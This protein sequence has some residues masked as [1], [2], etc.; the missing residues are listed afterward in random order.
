MSLSP[1]GFFAVRTPLLPIEAWL[2]WCERADDPDGQ[3]AVLRALVADPAVREALF[4]G[5]PDLEGAVGAWERE[6]DGERGRRVERAVLRY[7]SRMAT[8]P[9]P[10]GLFAGT[11]VGTIGDRTQLTLVARS[12]YR[13]RTR[14][15][16]GYLDGLA[17]ALAG[18][19]A[20]RGAM[21]YRPNSSLYATAGRL[22]YVESR[23][24]DSGATSG[25]PA[26]SSRR[27]E[28][29]RA[30]T[31]SDVA[32]TP[33][34]RATLARAEGA[35]GATAT[36]LADALASSAEGITVE[37]AT[38][39]VEELIENQLLLPE[40]PLPITGPEPI[41]PL[42]VALRAQH[43]AGSPGATAADRLAAVR[44]GIEA[45]DA[46]GLGAGPGRY[47]ALAGELA[48]LPAPVAESRLFQVDL[49]KPAA[50]AV[51]GRTVVAEIAR[52]VELLHRL[53]RATPDGLTRFRARFVERYEGRA[54]PLPEALDDE[55]GVGLDDGGDVEPLLRTLDLG[56]APARAP[57]VAWGEY[58][59]LLLA[60]L[61]DALATGAQEIVLERPDVDAL[62]A[63]VVPP[64]PPPAD[65]LAAMATVVAPS[66]EA[67]DRGD[68]RVHLHGVDG[69]SGARLLGRFCH[70]DAELCRCVAAHLRAEE[71]L[72]PDALYAE[73][74]HSPAGRVGNLLLRPL[75]REHEIVYLGHSG[76]PRERQIAAA[77]LLVSVEGDQVVLRLAADGRRV[78][79]RLTSAHNYAL[80]TNLATYR[81]LGALQAQGRW[82]GGHWE[83]G[84][85]ASAPFLP[86]VRAGRLVLAL[87]RWATPR[88]ELR[89]LE[90]LH[91]AALVDAVRQWRA[92]RH[93]PRHA[94]VVEVD[95]V[96]PLDLESALGAE[97][98]VH[99]AKQGGSV[100][101]QEVFPGPEDLWVHGPE[102]R[103]T[104]ELIVPFV[105]T[106]PSTAEAASAPG[107]QRRV[108]TSHGVSRTF[109]PGSEWLYAKLYSGPATADRVLRRVVAPLVRQARAAGW[110]DGWFFI[111][112]VD[113]GPHLR[114]RFRGA[115]A[116]LRD[117]LMP[118][119]HDSVAPLL[120]DGTVSRLQLDTYEREVDRYG[121][122]DGIALVEQL[123]E[124][125]S[126]AVVEM[127]TGAA[128]P[129][130]DDRWRVALVGIDLLL[131][132]LGMDAGER[133]AVFARARD[134][135]RLE[136]NAGPRL[137]R[138]LGERFRVER[139]TLQALL[140]GDPSSAPRAVRLALEALHRRAE[141]LTP[142]AAELRGCDAAGRLSPSLAEMAPSL[143]HMFAVR[144]LRS[145]ARAHE[146]VLYD[147]LC[148]LYDAQ[149]AREKRG[150][151]STE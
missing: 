121:G 26:G 39:Y 95:N 118:A 53:H 31:L 30:Y 59:T 50:E 137:G 32:D 69:P 14:L 113:P 23:R 128:A 1:S 28:F 45:L 91:G 61:A 9:T 132:A 92:R 6:P 106:T 103:F 77:D 36:E 99:L 87:A 124:A 109:P 93:V 143:T 29:S 76:A 97:A 127:I 22:R 70:G 133:R 2:S 46:A 67:I 88:A 10:F 140:A 94:A 78:V 38:R 142:I 34:L 42:E 84:A 64:P 130:G 102:G 86:R 146:V 125:D 117:S 58:E 16:G 18:E 100:V 101:L 51:L 52:G 141:R 24:E 57:E 148:R 7:V 60:R 107:R 108:A 114:V 40:L 75:L 96:L 144:L 20:L 98:F 43:P 33:Y 79:P 19:P 82:G 116:V 3:R 89:P 126:D 5:S 81:L 11:G 27:D 150:V 147:F 8:R 73:V 134:G 62:A 68:F 135:F 149:A 90:A 55:S 110:I 48:A 44:A 71:A 122:D 4:V 136:T 15:D 131:A 105:A 25:G 115:P 80:R 151:T 138:Q 123:F 111:R 104:H 74:V 13:R 17:T 145:S 139:A 112:Y 37:A 63:A 72:D 21:R 56:T 120:A 47:R 49:F 129:S 65:A 54:V 66:P 85:L 41:G 119:L 12:A 35:G 83:W